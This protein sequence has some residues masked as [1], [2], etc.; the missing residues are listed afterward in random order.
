MIY[1]RDRERA[2]LHE[3]LDDAIAGQGSLALISGEAG[4]G[5]T[6]LVDDLMHEAGQHDCLILSGGCYDLTTTPPYG[7]WVEITR[8]YVPDDELPLLPE[9]LVEGRG[10]DAIPSQSALFR[11]IMTFFADISA[12]RPLLIVLEDL[13]WSDLESPALLRY[14]ARELGNN[15]VLIVATYRDDELTRRDSFFQLIPIL[16]RES[17]ATRIDLRRWNTD[18]ISGFVR[19]QYRL[20]D[21]DFERLGSYLFEQTEGNPLFIQEMLSTLKAEAILWRSD[22]VWSLDAL[23]RVAVPPFVVQLIEGRLST[24]DAP[25][26]KL[27]ELASVI[28][29]EVSLEL[30][31]RF[32][33]TSADDLAPSLNRALETRLFDETVDPDVVQFRHALVREALYSGIMLLQRQSWHR[34]LADIMLDMEHPD[35][36]RLVTHLERASDP[37]LL[38]WLIRSGDSAAA[39]Y[40]WDTAVERYERAVTL[41]DLRGSADP[42]QLCEILLKL[43][44]AQSNAGT[45]RGQVRGAGNDPE[46][47]ATFWRVVDVARSA[48]LPTYLA[49]AALGIAGNNVVALHGGPDGVRL[50]AEALELLPDAES[51]IR[52]RLLARLATGVVALEYLELLTGIGTLEQVDH[53]SKRAVAMARRLRDRETLAYTLNC[54]NAIIEDVYHREEHRNNSA[55]LVTLAT[56]LRHFPLLADGLYSQIVGFSLDGDLDAAQETLARFGAVSEQLAMPIYDWRTSV[57]QSGLALSEGRFQAAARQIERCNAIWPQSSSGRTQELF[58]AREMGDLETMSKTERS[59]RA[60][61]LQLTD[62][63]LLLLESGQLESARRSFESYIDDGRFFSETAQRSGGWPY[64]MVILTEACR[65]LDD[66]GRARTL[67][68]HLVAY[69]GLNAFARHSLFSMGAIGHYLGLLA[70]AM[71]DF[72]RADEHFAQ[73][74]EQNEGWGFT[75]AAAYTCYEWARAL[76][77]RGDEHDRERALNLLNEAHATARKLGMVRLQQLTGALTLGPSTCGHRQPG[78]AFA[79]RDRGHRAGRRRAEQPRDRRAALHLAAHRLPAPALGL[80]QAQRQQPRRRLCPLDRAQPRLIPSLCPFPLRDCR[81]PNRAADPALRDYRNRRWSAYVTAVRRCGM[82][83]LLPRV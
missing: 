34:H 36:D 15:R 61:N 10:L 31:M 47:Q 75:P 9:P 44:N 71:G 35:P 50:T 40:A 52:A 64:A 30:L 49:E 29:Q 22:D 81:S 63:L 20:D 46:A 38:G 39:R 14:L 76:I 45:G 53:W 69:D 33:G 55:E 74:L 3:L 83:A 51:T 8:G 23:D 78:R 65:A 62:H 60:R 13:H 32:S 11:L 41:L 72:D 7:P 27:L 57:H 79:T 26:R 59:G 68:G 16:V 56:Q 19:Q 5:K 54:R 67:Y 73:A 12:Q 18:E 48:G 28:G 70:A 24:L 66:T 21:E 6:T 1:G 43:G 77:Q 80:Q 2:Q 58:F 17:G 42:A 37:R 4:I 82:R 25:T